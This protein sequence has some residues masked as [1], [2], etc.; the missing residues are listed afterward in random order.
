MARLAYN[1]VFTT[2]VG[3]SGTTITLAGPLTHSGGVNVPTISGGNYIPLSITSPTG[4]LLEIVHL[5]A[6]TAGATT[7]TVIR[8][9]EGT[10]A[11]GRAA[12]SLVVAA[13]T[14][15]D[16]AGNPIALPTTQANIVSS[17]L[18][19]ARVGPGIALIAGHIDIDIVPPVDPNTGWMDTGAVVPAHLRPAA[20]TILGPYSYYNSTVSYRYQITPTGAVQFQATGA[21]ATFATLSDNYFIPS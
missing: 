14:V 16:F 9:R 21:H 3:L 17:S 19:V 7:G 1:G 11:A 8:G 6:Y 12:G 15:D 13:P 10:T 5:T 18:Q 2:L 20:N 4:E